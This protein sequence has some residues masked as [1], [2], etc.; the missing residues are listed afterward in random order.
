MV[1]ERLTWDEMLLDLEQHKK[2]IL[3]QGGPKAVERHHKKG[4]LT[5]RER[6]GKFLDPGTF[7]EI[8]PFIR[9]RQTDFGMDKKEIA[10]EGVVVGFGE[11]NGRTVCVWS[12]DFTSTGGTMAEMHGFK[13]QELIQRYALQMRVPQIGIQDSGGIRLQEAVEAGEMGYGRSM[14]AII[15]ASGSIPQISLIMGPCGGGQGYL[16]ALTDIIIMVKGTSQ[17]YIGGPASIKTAL[18]YDTTIEEL[19]GSKVHSEVTG[20]ADIEVDNDGEA[21]EV[22]KN[23]LSYL[24]SSYESPLPVLDTTDS[25]DRKCNRLLEIVPARPTKSYDMYKVIKEIVDNGE[26]LELKNKY[27]KN[28]IIGFARFNGIPVGIQANQ[29]IFMGGT[30]DFKSAAKFARFIRFCDCFNI[31]LISL[32]DNPAYMPGVEQE[33]GGVVKEGSKHLHAFNEA[34][35]P[36]ISVVIRKAFAGGWATMASKQMGAD[37]VFVWPTAV[38]VALTPEAVVNVIYPP[39]KYGEDVRKEA[40]E[41]YYEKYYTPFFVAGRGYVEDIINPEDTRMK[42]IQALKLWM[43]KKA[44][45]QAPKKHSNIY[46]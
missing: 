25:P 11:T 37:I 14:S 27:A 42:I 43:G 12:Q 17:M 39:N 16:P 6:I 36:K 24:P 15:K 44:L 29:P 3:S 20:V 8:Y 2:K 34:T 4:L 7:V 31:P 33:H 35:I 45:P 40:V 13:V 46:L 30:L 26:F 21:L 41:M 1:V 18:G 9:H 10:A 19:G 28:A 32:V 23:I 5:A 38:S 22:C